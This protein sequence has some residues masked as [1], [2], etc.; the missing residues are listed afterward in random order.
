LAL[1]NE[2]HISAET[3][4]RVDLEIFDVAYNIIGGGEEG[5]KKR[6]ETKEQADHSLPYLIAVALLD[7]KVMPE[8][9]AANRI[10]R[11][12]VQNLLRKIFVRPDDAY[13]A[14]FPSRMSCRVTITLR[15]GS[16]I[17]R[18][19]GDYPGFLTHP[20]SWQDTVE[21]L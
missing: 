9:Y 6:V 13:S 16:R 17:S 12:D 5:D 21:N 20:M 10:G 7:G 19:Q 8:Q 15:D 4:G 14:Q 1:K 3:I 18:E 2:N 11:S